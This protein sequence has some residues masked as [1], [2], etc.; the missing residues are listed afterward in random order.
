MWQ[1]LRETELYPAGI[2]VVTVALDTGG[3]EAAA[4]FV[5]RADPQHPTLIDEAHLLDEKLGIV[6]VPSGLWIDETGTIVRP[7]EPAHAPNDQYARIEK[8]L[9]RDD[10]PD[11]ARQMAEETLRIRYEPEAYLEALRD[12][13][14]NGVDSRYVLRPD[15]VI[16]RSRP[17]SGSTA[18]AAACF[19]L[20]QHL[21]RT[22]EEDAATRWFREAHRLDP[23]N[24]TYK[25]QAWQFRSPILQGPTDVYDSDW[26]SDVREIGPENYY[27]PLELDPDTRSE[28]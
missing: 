19:E 18:R 17:V 15:E 27:P 13:A 9:E 5:E 21:H 24:W 23:D 28:A 11:R 20:G 12:W 4:P 22:G 10:L 8:L 14:A 2:E 25:R 6:N 3:A 1:E 26:L 7:P 16:E